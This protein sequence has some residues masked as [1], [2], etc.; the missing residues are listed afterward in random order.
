MAPIVFPPLLKPGDTIGVTAPSA[1]IGPE[2]EPRLQFCLQTLRE[3]GFEVRLGECLR[4]TDMVSAPAPA[5]ARELAGMLLDPSIQA[6][7]PPW[8]G[9]LLIDILPLLDF[10]ALAATQPKW[11]VGYSDLTTFLFPY[12]LLTHVATLHGSNLLET[13]NRAA[14]DP[15]AHW[16][17]VAALAPGATF[18]QGSARFYQAEPKDWAQWPDVTSF[19]VAEPVQW[20]HLHHEGDPGDALAVSGRLIGGC[21]D[22]IAMLAGTPYGDI[23]AFARA[24][25]PEG[26]LIYLENADGNTAQFCRL[27]HHA[28][29][30]GW[31][32]RANAVLIGRSAGPALREFSVRDALLDALG[33]LPAPVI[34]DMDIGHCPPQL[35]LVNGASALVELGPGRRR[36]AQTLAAARA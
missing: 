34:Y 16:L 32:G 10:G 18:E 20:K 9:E 30:A 12:T 35:I 33:D 23:D 24:C 3:R 31:F 22:V 4:S 6:V 5:R 36:V 28:R 27:L 1:G 25:A 19:N 26:L 13:P 15:L 7:V 8:G 29:L 2:L 11:V 17:D 14:P 21:L